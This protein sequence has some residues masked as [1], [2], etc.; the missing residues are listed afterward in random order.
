MLSNP[1][2]PDTFL[3][4]FGKRFEHPVVQTQISDSKMVRIIFWLGSLGIAA[5]AAFGYSQVTTSFDVPSVW[6]VVLFFIIGLTGLLS[7]FL[8]PQFK[9]WPK[10]KWPW[11]DPGH[12]TRCF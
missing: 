7:V 4:Y 11:M 8:F 10:R 9:N 2:Y 12:Q 1:Q 6:R 3:R 5:I